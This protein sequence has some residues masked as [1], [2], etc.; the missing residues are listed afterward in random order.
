MPNLALFNIHCKRTSD[1]FIWNQHVKTFVAFQT[2]N[3]VQAL[4]RK[5]SSVTHVNNLFLFAVRTRNSHHNVGRSLG[6][7]KILLV[8]VV[9]IFR[10]RLA[11]T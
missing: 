3:R 7:Q 10:L 9:A 8:L 6:F 1:Y 2:F 4:S 11:E 5:T